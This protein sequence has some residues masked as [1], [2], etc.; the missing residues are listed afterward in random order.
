MVKIFLFWPNDCC[1]SGFGLK[2]RLICYDMVGEGPVGD[3]VGAVGA[4]VTFLGS[5][6]YGTGFCQ[7]QVYTVT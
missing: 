3:N 2:S 7:P 5:Q 6:N 1:C 4:T